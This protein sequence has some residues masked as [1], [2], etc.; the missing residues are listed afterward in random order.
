MKRILL[1]A[2]D[3]NPYR[4]SESATGWNYPFNLSQDNKVTVVTRVNNLPEINRYIS[5]NNILTENLKF[6][7]FDLPLWAR[8]WKKGSRGSFLYFYLWQIFLGIKFFSK[9]HDF[10]VCHGLNFHCDWAPSFLW[11][12]GKPMVW[13]PINHNE[14]LPKYMTEGLTNSEIRNEKVKQIFKQLFWKFDPLLFICKIKSDR[15][16]VGHNDVIRRLNLKESKCV[17]FNQIATY[18]NTIK[19]VPTDNINILFVG[20][21][22]LIK[23]IFV[24]L[25][26]FKNC[27][28]EQLAHREQLSVTFVG[29]GS[30][31]KKK[32]LKQALQLDLE[33]CV[34]VVEWVSFDKMSKYYSDASIFCFPSFEG[35]GMV[36]AEALSYG[37]PVVTIERNGAAHELSPNCAFILP[38]NSKEE[39]IAGLTKAF[40]TLITDQE[41]LHRMSE[42]SYL[43][44]RDRL[45][46]SAKSQKISE[47][48]STL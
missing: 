39:V 30:E 38:N 33:H 41:L 42:Y 19:R 48:Y 46:W 9:R 14:V 13:G 40:S 26:A 27:Y 29:V 15:I 43:H 20:R 6:V 3:V 18:E 1:T 17:L 32:I 21:G 5:E 24:I 7:G 12:L 16:L 36:L 37:L 2:Y 28:D 44:T 31:A 34:D 4:G 47:I 8:F 25:D 11:L 45:S 23:N 22:L 35:A 10:D